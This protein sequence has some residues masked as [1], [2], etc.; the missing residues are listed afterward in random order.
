MSSMEDFIENANRMRM[1]G[2]RRVS[3]YFVP[4]LLVNMASSHTSETFGLRF[5]L[6]HAVHRLHL[7]HH[8]SGPSLSPSSACTSSA[9]AIGDAARLIACGSADRMLAGGAEACIHPLALAGFA[10]CR[11]LSTHFN[12]CPQLASRPFDSTR[13][14]FV[15]A[16]GSAILVLEALE[17]AQ[18]RSAPI[19]AHVAGYGLSSDA[20]HVTAPRSDGSGAQ[21]CMRAALHDA[22]LMPK[23]ISYLNAHATSTPVGDAAEATAIVEVFGSKGV[24]VSSTKGAMGHLLGAAG[25]VEA[26][27]S[28]MALC[29]KILP[30]N[31]NL[32]RIGLD[33]YVADNLD[34]LRR[35]RELDTMEAVMSNSFGFGGTNAS[36]IFT[37]GSAQ[38]LCC[39]GKPN[40]PDELKW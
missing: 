17:T 40:L 8:Y 3:P 31:V 30:P 13:D 7:T 22:D 36:L 34:L 16:E 11:A 28:I 12:K 2:P 23:D 20:Y 1:R 32:E 27:A 39:S 29:M 18:K 6:A 25:A 15:M 5:V 35:A 4:R 24:P 33:N 19:L 26:V 38:D 10:Q 9:H 37:K 21:Q 14:G